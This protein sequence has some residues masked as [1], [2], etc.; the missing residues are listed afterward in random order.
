[1]GRVLTNS[2]MGLTQDVWCVLAIADIQMILQETLPISRHA[3]LSQLCIA[4][5]P[6]ATSYLQIS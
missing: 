6:V 2:Y 4:E 3:S 1:M 5:I